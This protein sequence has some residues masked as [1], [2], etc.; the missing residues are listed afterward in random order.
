MP[1][2]V[3]GLGLA[4]ARFGKTAWADL[5][6]PAAR[7]AREGFPISAELAGSLNRQ[8]APRE[9]RA[10]PRRPHATTSAG[11]VI[12]RSRSPRSASPI[13]PPGRPATAG[14]ARPGRCLDRIAERG[15]R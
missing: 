13:A 7:L 15:R 11:W 5:V 10:R 14:P 1:G 4:H 9:S 3:R 8:L 12:S 2:T 6:R